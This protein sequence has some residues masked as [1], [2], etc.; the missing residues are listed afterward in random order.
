MDFAKW[1]TLENLAG[2]LVGL[3]QFMKDEKISAEEK[4]AVIE[5]LYKLPRYRSR[6]KVYPNPFGDLRF[7]LEW[8]RKDLGMKLYTVQYPWG[9]FPVFPKGK[10]ICMD[11]VRNPKYDLEKYGVPS[12][13]GSE[14]LTTRV[15]WHNHVGR[16]YSE[17]EYPDYSSIYRRK[18]FGQIGCAPAAIYH[19]GMQIASDIA[20]V[21]PIDYDISSW[22]PTAW[23]RHKPAQPNFSL[24]T[25]LGEARDLPR[26]LKA[27]VEG[28]K[29]FSDFWLAVQFGWKPLLQ[30]IR[31]MINFVDKMNK[32]IEFIYLNAGKPI[33][34]N[35][36][37][38][39]NRW[40]E[41]IYDKSGSP[42][43]GL[44]TVLGGRFYPKR[45]A[46]IRSTCT[47]HY[48][49][50]IRFSG[51]FLYWFNGTPPEYTTL[52]AKLAGLELTPQV[53]WNLI[54][55]SWLVDWFTNLGD[56]IDNLNTEV[57]DGQTSKYA[58]ITGKTVRRYHW[59]GTDG[60]LHASIDRTF[61]SLVRKNVNPFGVGYNG[62]LSLRQISILAAL[63]ISRSPRT[64]P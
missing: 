31:D 50:T 38:Y 4:K 36:H 59:T 14:L 57:A 1:Y 27:R 46:S 63:G 10:E 8:Y 53:V 30:D 5:A 47:C 32:Q 64:N 11:Y 54:P 13:T 52:A 42:Y 23:K 35:G 44:S 48:E 24:A 2:L 7:R 9:S 18:G 56:V 20:S 15:Y 12:D 34:R 6:T 62:T 37:V 61:E 51:E 60:Y 25:F 21:P 22:G 58:Y 40:V 29:T 16:M 3:D 45:D 17:W 49:Q 28:L 43:E 26:L 55:W 19:D 41:R 33:R 39:S